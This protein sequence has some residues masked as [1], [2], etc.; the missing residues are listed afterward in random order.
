MPIP[1]AKRLQV[2]AV[3]DSKT[4]ICIQIQV[5]LHNICKHYIFVCGQKINMLQPALD[6]EQ[7]KAKFLLTYKTV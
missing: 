7:N 3:R 1:C 2:Y 6:K 5:Y 4:D